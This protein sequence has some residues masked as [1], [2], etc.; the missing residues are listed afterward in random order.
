MAEHL[1]ERGAKAFP[2]PASG[3]KVYYDAT[4][5]GFGLRVTAAGVRSFVLNYMIHGKER[6]MTIG[7]FPA[8][9]VVKARE[10]ASRLKR[11][12][13][14]GIDPLAE[15][16]A[17]SAEFR[18]EDQ[19]PNLSTLRDFYMSHHAPK[20]SQAAAQDD[21]SMFDSHIVRV[22]GGNTKLKDIL[23]Y[24]VERLHLDLTMSGKRVRANRCVTL[25]K[26]AL[27]LAVDR[28]WIEKNPAVGLKMNRENHVER[29]VK[30]DEL[31]K[32]KQV[33]N[34]LSNDPT[35]AQA[36]EYQDAGDAVMLLLLTG[37]RKMEVLGMKWDH[38][39]LKDARWNKPWIV[40]KSGK[41]HHVPLSSGAIEIL[42]RRRASQDRKTL[43]VF[44][45][46]TSASGH[47]TTIKKAWNTIKERSGLSDVRGHDLRHSFASFLAREGEGLG[48]IGELLGHQDTRTTQ[49][50]AH[51][52]D[53]DKRDA[54]AAADRVI[55]GNSQADN[56]MLAMQKLRQQ[57]AE[58]ARE[59]GVSVAEVI[60]E[61]M[62]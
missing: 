11:M 9:S 31:D 18:A 5:K 47:I 23:K 4:L 38:I 49:R 48:M 8:W 52:F 56:A 16:E 40:T 59:R 20:K 35:K 29:P 43:F 27:N 17:R 57:A 21:R 37:G 14:S 58:I 55:S 26:T 30:P 51:Y 19:A 1:T 34:E 3:N 32:L 53:D 13:D 33:M 28:G 12:I 10:E 24:D 61:L 42:Q 15:K 46:D 50:Y 41:N 6:R 39:D 44:P 2:T 22:I 60:A 7:Q 54:T 25:F 45:S 62:G 36:K